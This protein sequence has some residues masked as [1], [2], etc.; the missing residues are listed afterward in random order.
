M[1][2][3]FVEYVAKYNLLNEQVQLML[4]VIATHLFYACC[5]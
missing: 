3:D 2:I 1:A 5:L 4:T